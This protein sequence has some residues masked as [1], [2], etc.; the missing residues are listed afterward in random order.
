MK[1]VTLAGG[2]GAG[3]FLRGVERAFPTDDLTVVVNTGDDIRMHGLHISPDLDSVCYWLAGVMDRGRGWGRSDETFH[4]MESLREHGSVDAWFNLGDRDLATHLVRT[5]LLSEG[6]SLS[7]ATAIVCASLF[8]LRATVL[9]MTDMPVPTRLDVID[10]SGEALDLHFQ[11]YWVKRQATDAVKAV[12]SEGI[13]LATPAPYVLQ[14]I[15][16]ADVLLIAPS[17]PV[18]SIGPILSVPGI[19]DT[20]SARPGPV[21]GVSPI[22]G[23]APLAGM[24][25][26][27]MPVAGLEVSAAGAARA[28]RDLLTGWVIDERDRDAARAIGDELGVRVSVGDTVMVD[29]D[30]AAAVARMAIDLA[31]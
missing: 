17:N 31:T 9:P 20:V 23:G 14:T 16:E 15:V 8:G 1:I 13:G 3:K 26:K 28:Y 12:R 10:G 7:E 27:L 2:V 29:D 6:R 25:D 11:E 30:V 18:V 5:E 4:A 22:V 21:V 19:R 24:A